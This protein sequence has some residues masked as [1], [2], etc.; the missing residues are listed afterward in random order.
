MFLILALNFTLLLFL[1]LISWELNGIFSILA[2]LLLL[3]YIVCLRL[4]RIYLPYWRNIDRFSL[5]CFGNHLWQKLITLILLIVSLLILGHFPWLKLLLPAMNNSSLAHIHN[6]RFSFENL[7]L[8]C[9]ILKPFVLIN[10]ATFSL[11]RLL[12]LWIIKF[13]NEQLLNLDLLSQPLV[14]TL[15]L[16]HFLL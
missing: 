13:L 4:D 6:L 1:I 12:A 14:F 15:F 8:I 3:N 7:N 9:F 5:W 10:H 11:G 16:N 2:S